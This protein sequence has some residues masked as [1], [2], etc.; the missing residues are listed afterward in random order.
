MTQRF[1]GGYAP[2]NTRYAR[3]K[4][5]FAATTGYHVLKGDAIKALTVQKVRVYKWVQIWFSGIPEGVKDTGGKSWLYPL[6]S[7]KGKPKSI[8]MYMYVGEYGGNYGKGGKHPKRAVFGPSMVEY[9]RQGQKKRGGEYLK[10]IE[11]QW[12]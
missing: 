2:Y 11:R 3:W 1:A 10:D 5:Q 6:G 8:A 4:E 12:R 7:L 9:S